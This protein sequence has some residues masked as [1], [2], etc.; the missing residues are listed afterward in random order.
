MTTFD[1]VIRDIRDLRIQGAATIARAGLEALSAE[2][3]RPRVT[4]DVNE[5]R[6]QLFAVRPNEPMLRNLVDRYLALLPPP[7]QRSKEIVQSTAERLLADLTRDE[8]HIAEVAARLL[9]GKH[10]VFTHCH[11]STVT[12]AIRLAAQQGARLTVFCTETRPRYQGR[13]TAQEL[14]AAGVDVVQLVDG[15]AL[16]ALREAELF[17]LGADAVLATGFFVN[18]VGSRLLAMAAEHLD[19][20]LYV[21][22]HTLKFDAAS[23]E[24]RDDPIEERSPEE[25]WPEHPAAVQIRN[26][27]FERVPAQYVEGFITERGL[28]DLRAMQTFAEE[29]R[30]KT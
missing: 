18:K 8:Q 17:M 21:C 5:L 29:H 14:A 22:C 10:A 15:A 13:L 7:T 25:V 4:V 1:S 2:M 16:V 23:I 11:S 26:P 19:V 3:I 24:G 12:R 20:P 9:D 28:I 30:T 27:A 6:A